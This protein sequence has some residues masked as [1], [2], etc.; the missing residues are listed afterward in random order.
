MWVG[1]VKLLLVVAR[2]VP[3][4]ALPGPEPDEVVAVLLLEIEENRRALPV[5]NNIGMHCP[6]CTGVDFPFRPRDFVETTGPA[7]QHHPHE[8]SD[9]T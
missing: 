2:G 7:R 4:E 5:A 6:G 8:T 1:G 3:L 9:P